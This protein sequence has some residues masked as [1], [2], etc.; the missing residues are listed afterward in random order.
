M[1]VDLQP[2]GRIGLNDKWQWALEGIVI[3]ARKRL[4]IRIGGH[5]I[6]GTIIKTKDGELLWSSWIDSVSLPVTYFIR[7]R[8]PKEV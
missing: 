6:M 4:E 7:A 1:T 2:K 8:W 5:W 3:E